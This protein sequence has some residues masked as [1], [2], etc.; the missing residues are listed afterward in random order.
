MKQIVV[1]GGRLQGLETLYLAA[2]AGIYTTLIDKDDASIGQNFCNRFIHKDVIQYVEELL[3]F[4]QDADF[5]LPALENPQ[6]LKTLLDLKKKYNINLIHDP[7]AYAI[8]SS[9]VCSDRI[10]AAAGIPVPQ[11]YPQG[12][13]PYIAKPSSMSGSEGVLRLN[14]QEDVQAFLEKHS[15]E[16]WVIEE[17]LE[18]PSYSIEIIG[19]PGQYKVYHITELFMDENYDCKRVMSCPDIDPALKRQFQ[20]I[21]Y[22]LGDIVKLH[23]IMD[24][25]VIDCQGVLKVLE[26]DVRHPSQTP[27]NIYHATGVNFIAELHRVFCPGSDFA[28]SPVEENPQY[29]SLEQIEVTKDAI[30]VL[31]EHI[32]TQGQ[33]L[34]LEKNFCG[35]DQAF[36]NYQPGK[37]SWVA[38]VI[39]KASNSMALAAKRENMFEEIGKLMGG[40]LK[41][42]DLLPL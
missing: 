20:D 21:A 17:Y 8:S 13:P 39:C 38:T 2:E 36:T 7:D 14:N 4:F 34:R 19:L 28:A 15:V 5:V 26:I 23:G 35:A 32:L 16:E 10:M 18:G 25:E 22:R 42:A 41:V 29:V 11:H 9:K 27:I 37:D 33:G 30:T 6:A 1:V 31:G 40:S 3:S 12:T 24:V